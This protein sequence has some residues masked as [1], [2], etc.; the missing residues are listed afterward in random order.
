M[1]YSI[2]NSPAILNSANKGKIYV[3]K[4]YLTYSYYFTLEVSILL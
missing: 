4:Y 3:V 2:H 1:P